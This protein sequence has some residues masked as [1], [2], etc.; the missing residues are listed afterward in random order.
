MTKKFTLI[1]IIFFISQSVF[2][3][4]KLT[5]LGK[6]FSFTISEPKGWYCEC[7]GDLAANIG[8]NA[9]M[10]RR[11]E[12]METAQPLIY[13]RVNSRGKSAVDD[14]KSGIEQ[15]KKQNSKIQFKDFKVEN[16][17]GETSAKI[18]KIGKDAT[19][20]VVYLYPKKSVKNAVSIAMH[21]DKREAS[22]EEIKIF[23][24]VVSSINWM[25]DEAIQ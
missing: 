4:K 18:F 8:A 2:A 24:T 17:N 16:A 9:A 3:D 11:G 19:E 5:I 1:A 13:L 10:W 25:A 22:T 12:T 6:E 21:I 23:Q 15:A 20:Y 7:E 14:I